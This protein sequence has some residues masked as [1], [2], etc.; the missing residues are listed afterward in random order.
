MSNTWHDAAKIST[1]PTHKWHDVMFSIHRK[2]PWA[3]NTEDK[4]SQVRTIPFILPHIVN[5]S[6]PPIIHVYSIIIIQFTVFLQVPLQ[7]PE[8][9]QI[10][11]ISGQQNFIPQEI[12]MAVN[13]CIVVKTFKKGNKRIQ[14]RW[15]KN[16][17]V[18]Y[19]CKVGRYGSDT[20]IFLHKPTTPRAT[21][22]DHERSMR[23]LEGW[24]KLEYKNIKKQHL[25]YRY[26]K[27]T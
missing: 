19:M 21:L 6:I 14:T 2:K 24:L 10:L 7:F 18:S 8:I 27:S 15:P 3:R 17:W 26:T 13:T 12:S 20:W 22:I 1:M 25:E 23:V 4:N 16:V 5:P 9:F 11:I